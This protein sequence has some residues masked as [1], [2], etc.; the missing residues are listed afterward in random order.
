MGCTS[1]LFVCHGN[2]CRSTMAEFVMRH[3]V[4]QAGLADSIRVDSA[5]TSKEELGNDVHP[6]TRGKLGQMG[7]P[8]GHHVSR[9][10]G[11]ADYASFDYIV[12]M[13]QDNMDGIYRLLLGEKGYGWSWDPV[14]G[15]EISRADPEEK[16]S[17]L[18]SWAGVDRDVAD[19]WYTGNFD[20]TYD[21]V[22]LGCTALLKEI[23]N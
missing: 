9:Q 3:L 6:G 7:G 14:S 19:P 5:A 1:I 17:R 23:T 21:D 12:G 10:M 15:A 4:E 16:V 13:D 22:L 18:L 2:I 20:V 8:C 11:P